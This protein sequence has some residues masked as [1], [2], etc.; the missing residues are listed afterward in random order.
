MLSFVCSSPFGEVDRF[1][2]WSPII[3]H[4][5]LNQRISTS[6]CLMS[7]VT[8]ACNKLSSIFQVLVVYSRRFDL[9]NGSELWNHSFAILLMRTCDHRWFSLVITIDYVIWLY[10]TPHRAA[11][12]SFIFLKG[13]VALTPIPWT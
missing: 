12:T 8:R 6:K 4:L 9:T 11:I 1:V 3:R 10:L 7:H 2:T 13:S 5:N